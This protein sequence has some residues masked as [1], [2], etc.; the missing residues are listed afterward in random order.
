MKAP[1]KR[2]KEILQGTEKILSAIQDKIAEYCDI[3][4]HFEFDPAHPVVRLHEPTFGADEISTALE[5]LLST[6]V[7][8]GDRVRRFER[9]FADMFGFR[10]GITNNS[11]SS[12]N[13]LAISA[14]ANG[15]LKGGFRPGDEV[16]VPALSWSTTVWP[17]IQNSLIPVIVD[18]DKKTLNIDPSQVEAAIGP[19]TRGIMPVH[20]YGNPCD[21][22]ALKSIAERHDLIMVEDCCEA[23]G[24]SYRDQSVG[25]FGRVGTFSFYFSHHMTTLE[26]GICVS[27]DLELAELMRVLRAHGWVREMEGGRE[28]AARYPDIDPRFLFIN[29]G[30]N[31]RMTE[32]QG[33]MG[34]VQLPKLK[35]FVEARRN[36]S[37]AW[38]EDLSR[39]SPYMQFQQETP[40]AYSS[41]FG[42]PIL[43]SDKAPFT[44]KEIT[45]FLNAGH[46]E[47]RPIICGN[48]ALQPAMQMYK[49]R[50]FGALDH[51][52]AVMRRGFSFGNHQ[53]V[54]RVARDYV[55]A[56][57][58]EF[59]MNQG[60]S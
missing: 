30:Y 47:T 39:W 49:H 22:D 8:M 45:Q 57:I 24:A 9:E 21:M 25:K 28:V 1:T 37:A 15:A 43:L 55:T 16:I 3:A 32:L 54:D 44:V 50:T 26:G 40:G 53:S 34:S 51:S 36:N 4:H 41:C 35:G 19:K 20:V 6:H 33:A 48:I 59:M 42:F 14:L 23:L 31:L 29:L 2:G 27:N 12:A 60:L 46:I 10:H 56:K 52:T 18:I 5:I 7:T 11:G 58:G 13:L 17:L 38:R